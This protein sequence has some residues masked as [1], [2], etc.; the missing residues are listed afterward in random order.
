MTLV[1]EIYVPPMSA[2]A[3]TVAKGQTVR[4]ID[5]EGK[6]AG[7]FVAFKADDIS[8][9]FSQ[10]RTRVENGRVWI[11]QGH[12]LWTDGLPPEVL[13]TI[14]RDTA[15][16]H[17]LVYVPCCRYALKKRFGVSRDGCHENLARALESWGLSAHDIPPPLNIFFNVSVD[18]HGLIS[19]REPTSAMGDAIDL[20]A[21]MDT[22]VAVSTCSV[23]LPDK[24]N[25]AYQI[26][27]L[28]S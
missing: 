25:S 23:P 2:K 22:I 7:D 19:I 3:F 21:E 26:K 28:K 10:A 24:E 20:R 8:V 15:G 11:T 13:F 1:N 18:S 12:S 6:Q 14:T 4:I 27:I 17:D 16:R 5:L 9:R